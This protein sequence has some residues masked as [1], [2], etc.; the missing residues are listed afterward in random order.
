MASRIAAV[1]QPVLH[2]TYLEEVFL[3]F[4]LLLGWSFLANCCSANDTLIC[5]GPIVV[6][7]LLAILWFLFY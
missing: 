1:G 2:W 5:G 4:S 7:P 3:V 6:A